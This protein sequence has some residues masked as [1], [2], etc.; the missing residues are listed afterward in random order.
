MKKALKL[1]GHFTV[2][3]DPLSSKKFLHEYGFYYCDTLIEP[4]CRQS[5]FKYCKHDDVK[6][7]RSANIEDLVAISHGAFYGRFHRDFNIDKRLAD[8]RYDTWLRQLYDAGNVFSIMFD[9]VV[10]AF[11]GYSANK[12]VL[13]AMAKKYRGKGLAKYLWSAACK[14]LF[15]MGHGEIASSI[16]ISNIPAVNLYRSLGFKFRNPLDVYHRFIK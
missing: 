5:D 14:E 12:I 9:N 7:S 13:H 8:L 3:V 1:K 2:R 4:Y 6:L 15:A 16:S 10:A 11:F